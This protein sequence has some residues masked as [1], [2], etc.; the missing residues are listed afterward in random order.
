MKH[1]SEGI[2]RWMKGRLTVYVCSCLEEYDEGYDL[3]FRCESI[4]LLDAVL[5]AKAAMVRL[6]DAQERG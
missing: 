6:K 5:D 1:T 4:K 2:L 3:C